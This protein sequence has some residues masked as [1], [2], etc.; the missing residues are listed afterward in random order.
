MAIS[1]KEAMNKIMEENKIDRRNFIKL[2]SIGAS[3]VITWPLLSSCNG[4]ASQNDNVD[5]NFQTDVD[6][7]LTAKEANVQLLPGN[8]TKV[9][10]FDGNLISGDKNALQKLGMAI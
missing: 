3:V 1:I 7:E 6:I 10:M 8:K 5:P 2:G 9:W 4:F